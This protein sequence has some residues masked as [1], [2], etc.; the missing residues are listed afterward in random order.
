MQSGRGDR[1]QA[2]AALCWPHDIMRAGTFQA[3]DR[4]ELGRLEARV[5]AC[6]AAPG[7]KPSGANTA[8]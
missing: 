8:S 4:R 7:N 3:G 2:C 5:L 6:E 1:L